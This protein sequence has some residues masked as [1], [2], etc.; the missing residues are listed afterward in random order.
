MRDIGANEYCPQ[1]QRHAGG[2]IKN[3]C[4]G[5]LQRLCFNGDEELLGFLLRVLLGVLLFCAVVISIL[6]A[7]SRA[8]H[9][10]AHAIAGVGVAQ[11]NTEGIADLACRV[12]VPT[13]R[14]RGSHR[15]NRLL[16]RSQLLMANIVVLTAHSDGEAVLLQQLHESIHVVRD[17]AAALPL[18]AAHPRL[19]LE[20]V[21][22]GRGAA[23]N[24][25]HL[26]VGVREFH[27]VAV[28]RVH[29]AAT[30]GDRAA[31]LSLIENAGNVLAG[32]AERLQLCLGVGGELVASRESLQ[33]A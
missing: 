22:A 8:A 18:R 10:T 33:R 13:L 29:G 23:T 21:T 30:A 31:V 28:E 5:A 2:S 27:L 6:D 1:M 4:A 17:F 16:T 7:S 32:Q 15:G 19:R 11:V 24:T 9:N 3:R 25:N 20:G 26:L 14:I 12:Q